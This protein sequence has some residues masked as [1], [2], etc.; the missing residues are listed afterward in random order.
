MYD[1]ETCQS[2]D[3]PGDGNCAKCHGTGV[4]QDVL[5]AFADAL[6]GVDQN[7]ERCGGSGKCQSC[8]GKGFVVK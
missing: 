7:C 2:C 8:E 6:G 1:V 3:Y 4:V 5:E